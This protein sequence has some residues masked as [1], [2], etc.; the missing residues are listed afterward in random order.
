MRFLLRTLSLSYVRRHRAKTFL[1][2]L[3]VVV[4]VATYVAVVGARGSLLGGIRETVDRMAGK[5]QLQLTQEGGVPEELQEAIRERPG[6][7]R[8]VARHRAGRRSRAGRAGEPPRPRRRPPRRP[9][10]ARL[11]LR[12]GGRRPRRP[13][14]LPRA[15]RLGRRRPAARRKGGAE[16]GRRPRPEASRRA[17]ER[18][19]PRA[20]DAEGLRRGL[21]RE[22]RR[23]GR[24][25]RA[26]ALRAR[27]PLRP[28]RGPPR[29]GGDARGRDGVPAGRRPPEREGRDARP[30]ERADGEARRE[31]RRRLR[32]DER[33]RPRPRG[34]P[35]LQRLQRRREPPPPRHRHSPRARRHAPA[36]PGALPPRGARPRS[37]RFDPRR[38]RGGRP[39]PRRARRHAAGGRAGLRRH[40]L[41]RGA[42]HSPARPPGARPRPPRV[43]RRRFRPLEGRRGRLADGG[44]REGGPPGGRGVERAARRRGTRPP[45]GDRRPR[46]AAPRRGDA[47]DPDDRRARGVLR[48]SPRRPD[49]ASPPRARGAARRA[50]LPG[51]GAPRLRR[52]SLVPAPE[53]RDGDGDDARP[54]VRRRDR[55]LHR[56]DDGDARAV[57]EG[58]PHLRHLRPRLGELR[59]P[60]LPLRARGEGRPPDGP[61]R[62]LRRVVPGPAARV[63][64]RDDRPRLHR[65]G[66]DA[67]PDPARLGRGERGDRP[68]RGGTRRVLHRLRQLRAE[69]RHG[70]RR[71]RR[72]ARGARDPSASRSPPS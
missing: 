16:D 70:R 20:P 1:T 34:V 21:R 53:R 39:H 3:G 27:A 50:P 10:D 66:A 69:V 36:G 37:R 56:G 18:D 60:R 19:D 67:R 47:D 64:G 32:R 30:Q 38:P 58:H 72:A 22:P 59:A 33:L 40:R 28:A 35:D 12:G 4:G 31:L 49:L 54:D 48:A 15:G 14:P 65:H 9:R 45:G 57:D 5:A 63:P 23:H 42:P 24:L 61:R 11:R 41:L 55:R 68:S 7:S 62:P 2:L 43:A 44:L 25:R 52:P 71:R 26:G 51:G 29:G 8:A 17:A 6:H 13:A 46:H